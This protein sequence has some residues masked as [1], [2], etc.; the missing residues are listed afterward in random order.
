MTA[1][2]VRRSTQVSQWSVVPCPV[3]VVSI[4]F[5]DTHVSVSMLFIEINSHVFISMI[6]RTG[7]N[8]LNKYI[9]LCLCEILMAQIELGFRYFEI[10]SQQK[11][12]L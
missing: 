9:Y 12:I 5:Y 10:Q 2:G 11:N 8:D 6:I 1:A 4:L 7:K 3:G